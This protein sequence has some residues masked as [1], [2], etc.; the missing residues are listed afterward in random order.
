MIRGVIFD[1]DGLMTDTERLFLR[2][3][4]E[5]MTE[6][7]EPEHQEVVTHCIGL[8]HS[9]TQEYVRRTLGMN[10]DYQGVM[11]EVARRSAAFCEEC[12]VPVKPG[13]YILL[14]YLDAEHIPYAVATSTGYKNARWRL[15]NIGVMERLGGLVTGDMVTAGKPDPE[16]FEKAAAAL[17]LSACQCMALEDSPHGVL[18][19]HRAGCLPV[20][21]PDLREPDPET[22]RL[23]FG[24]ADR[25]D[26]VIEILN[27]ANHT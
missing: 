23:L 1:M 2:F 15:E 10:F 26:H 17:E 16:I 18:A 19:A 25:L 4:R 24:T 21:I 27:R 11:R 13:L 20:M 9:A 5:V 6:R 22:F 12:G 14:D 8:N 3:W 7:G